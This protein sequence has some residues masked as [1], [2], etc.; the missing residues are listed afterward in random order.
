M[1]G[2]RGQVLGGGVGGR[3]PSDDDKIENLI[4]ISGCAIDQVSGAV[5]K[6]AVRG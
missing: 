2:L 4:I 1:D 5:Y 3:R 6:V